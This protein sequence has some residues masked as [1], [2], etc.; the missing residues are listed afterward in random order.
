ML[1]VE[2]KN[3]AVTVFLG[4]L[5]IL[6]HSAQ[7]PLL[8]FGKAGFHFTHTGGGLSRIHNAVSGWGTKCGRAGEA[9]FLLMVR[10]PHDRGGTERGP[11]HHRWPPVQFTPGRPAWSL[12]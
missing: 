2:T 10:T 7:Q 8:E 12:T 9:G 6:R 3:D 4:D 11:H 5:P 1:R